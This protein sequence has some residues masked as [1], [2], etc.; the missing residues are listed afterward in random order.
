MIKILLVTD[1][2][3]LAEWSHPTPEI[4]SSNP[5]IGK[6]FEMYTLLAN[7]KNVKMQKEAGKGPLK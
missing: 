1:M 7:C 2:T 3:Q 5:N 6:K 4:P